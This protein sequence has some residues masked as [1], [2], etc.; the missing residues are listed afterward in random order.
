[1]MGNPEYQALAQDLVQFIDP[2]KTVDDLWQ[3]IG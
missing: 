1:M 3:S 2:T